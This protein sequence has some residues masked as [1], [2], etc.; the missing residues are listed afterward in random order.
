MTT[1]FRA[2]SVSA[3]PRQSLRAASSRSRAPTVVFLSQSQ[4]NQHSAHG[5]GTDDKACFVF[6]FGA[7]PLQLCQRFARDHRPQRRFT[8][9][10]D[11][12]FLSALDCHAPCRFIA[13]DV[14]LGAPPSPPLACG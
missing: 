9:L 2:G 13:P 11:A 12:P 7:I 6:P 1:T 10:V 3:R 14:S 5:L 4:P 8:L